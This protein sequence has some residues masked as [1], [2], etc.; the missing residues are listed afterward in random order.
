MFNKI[1]NQL[2]SIGP[3]LSI[4]E[5]NGTLSVE[6]DNYILS[7][8]ESALVNNILGLWPLEKQRYIKLQDLDS[9][10][11]NVLKNGWTTSYG[12][13]LGIDIQDITLLNGAFT[14]AKEA[15]LMGMNDPISIVDLDG[16]SHSLS[17]QNLT[18][19]MLQYGQARASLSNSYAA[20]KQSINAA[21]TIQE[22]E[23]INTNI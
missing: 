18:I 11:K 16:A 4:L 3:V 9:S 1:L 7:S 13:K 15:S 23:A 17:L 6:F 19:L 20:I 14:L 8:E 5:D 21:T 22:L 2:N 10:W 12:Y